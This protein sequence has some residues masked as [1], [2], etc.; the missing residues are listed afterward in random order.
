MYERKRVAV[1]VTHG[2][3][4]LQAAEHAAGDRDRDGVR[5]R[6][7]ELPPQRRERRSGDVVEDE[8]QLVTVG[9]DVEDRADVR[10]VDARREPRLVDHHRAELRVLGEVRMQAL[11]GD[12]TR[13]TRGADVSREV[14]RRRTTRGDLLRELIASAR[15]DEHPTCFQ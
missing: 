13:E 1:V 2:V 4:S 9:D 10:V 3:R 14:Y 11:D 12:D 15:A 6:A 5:D 7:V 8:R